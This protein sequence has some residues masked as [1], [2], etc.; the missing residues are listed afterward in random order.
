MFT[1]RCLLIFYLNSFQVIQS[2]PGII[3]IGALFTSDE[4]EELLA[5]KIAVER[6]NNDL[7]LI[8]PTK[9]IEEIEIVEP[10]DTF[11]AGIKTCLMVKS[12]ISAVFGPLNEIASLHVRSMCD[13]MEMPHIE[14]GWNIEQQIQR[15]SMN[16]YPHPK[17]LVKAFKDLIKQMEWESFALMYEENIEIVFAT[18]FVREMTSS[19]SQQKW[20]IH[21]YKF[22]DEANYRNDFRDVLRRKERNILLH[23]KTENLYRALK[24]DFHTIDYEDFMYCNATIVCYTMLHRTSP[25]LV[26]LL[27]S[28]NFHASNF[29]MDVE[30]PINLKTSTALIYDA[31]KHFAKSI[32]AADISTPISRVPSNGQ[33]SCDDINPWKQGT[34]VI[35]QMRAT[36]SSGITGLVR[37]NLA[38]YRSML[39]L[40]LEKLDERGLVD[41]GKWTDFNDTGLIARGLSKDLTEIKDIHNKLKGKHF[42]VSTFPVDPYTMLVQSIKPLTGNDVYEGFCMDI[43]QE[44]SKFLGFTYTIKIPNVK[45]SL[46]LNVKTGKWEGILGDVMYAEGD[47]E[48]LGIVDLTVTKE[49]EELVDFSHPFLNTGIGIL[50]KK[51]GKS[52]AKVYA[53]LDPFSA[54]VWLC[55]VFSAILFSFFKHIIGRVSPY[56]WTNPNP[57]RQDEDIVE[58][59]YNLRNSAWFVV[60]TLMQQGSDIAPK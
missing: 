3:R 20:K 41:I 12:G 29:E 10:Y 32:K 35:N 14:V 55:T 34:T 26:T 16:F 28:W 57:C 24:Q 47:N 54:P 18:E 60:G 49:R 22:D 40:H 36:E 17:M 46:K 19:E 44:L 33:K 39:S 8:S 51:P 48:V 6:V 45:K 30:T 43:I 23:V 27:H 25:E 2:L 58:N 42:I 4:E 9:L 38:G 31:V 5:F 11:Q 56:E 13:S 15:H 53:F 37:F 59:S 7:M 50:F 52:E 21:L 1:L